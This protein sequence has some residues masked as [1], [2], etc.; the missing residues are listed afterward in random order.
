MKF[1]DYLNNVENVD[2]YPIIS[3]L[4]FSV[5]FL[6]AVLYA[7]TAS[8]KKMDDNANIPMK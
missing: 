5:V 6:I 8:K 3:L 7:F 1:S 2:I 4:I